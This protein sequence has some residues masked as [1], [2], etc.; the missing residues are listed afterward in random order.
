[1][2]EI[3]LEIRGPGEMAG[4][5]QSGLPDLKMASLSDI[6]MVGK[7]RKAAEKIITSGIEKYPEL[8]EKVKEYESEKHLE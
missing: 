8:Y 7:A 4:I 1:M 2:A 3:D 6:I 5:R